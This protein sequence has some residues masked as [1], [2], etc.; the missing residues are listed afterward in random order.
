MA[1]IVLLATGGTIA[2]TTEGGTGYAPTVTADQ[3][4]S[5]VPSEGA[6]KLEPQELMSKAGYAL[7]PADLLVILRAV[8]TAVDRADVAG[9]IVTCGTAAMEELPLLIDLA[10]DS[11]KLVVVTGAMLHA[12]RPGYDG[13]RNL[14]D[15]IAAIADP[16]SRQRGTLVLL[17]GELHD[18]IRARK[19]HKTSIEPLVSWP[20]G[21][22]A[23]VDPHGVTWWRT[24]RQRVTLGIPEALASIATIADGLGDDGGLIDLAVQTGAQGIVVEGMPGGGGVTVGV[25]AAVTRQLAA[26]IPV[27]TTSRSP[28]GRSL[29]IAGGGTGPRDLV[30]A[31][32]IVCHQLSA[33]KARIILLLALARTRDPHRLRAWFAELDP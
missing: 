4:A 13:A 14:A 29:H 1:L 6:Y 33:A 19:V 2:S 20:D 21:P 31:G 16:A 11:D 24:P 22:V 3:L 15:A 32:A 8:Q 23:S 25:M 7:E 18:P 27:V 30:A 28:L 5:L 9:V 17:G 12:T 26:G 10:I